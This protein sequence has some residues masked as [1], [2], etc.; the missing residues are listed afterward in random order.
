MK[1][2][3]LKINI[4]LNIIRSCLS[5][6]FPLITYPYIA[7]V[8]GVEILGK[9]N[10]AYSIENYFALI[11]LLGIS[12]YA[13]RTGSRCRDYKTE[14]KIFADQVYTVNLITTFVSYL[15]LLGFLISIPRLEPYRYLILLQSM[16]IL[17][18][19]IGADWINTIF[20]D[21][22]YV[23]LRTIFIYILNLILLFVFVNDSS[24]YYIYVGITVIIN[25]IIAL[26][27]RFYCRRYVNLC[28]TKCP[29]L[30]QHLSKMIIFF[31]NNLAITIYVTADITMLGWMQGDYFVGLYVIA[32]KVYTIVKSVLAATYTAVI[33]RLSNYAM[34]DKDEF[35]RLFDLLIC[36][37]TVIILPIAAILYILAKP[38]VLILAGSH[39]ID[40][41]YS[42]EI[43]CVSLVFSIFGGAIT[44]CYNIPLEKEKINLQA[45]IISAVLN[46]V[47]NIYFIAIYNH[48]GAA[49]TTLLSEFFIVL[50]CSYRD[51]KM[52]SR[53]LLSKDFLSSFVHSTISSL[54]IILIGKIIDSWSFNVWIFIL[55]ICIVAPA[56][57]V[58]SMVC[59]K[60]K[61]FVGMALGFLKK[62]KVIK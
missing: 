7:R 50:Y 37:L 53:Y 11:A 17:F 45:T 60:D 30:K 44:N 58:V 12:T 43:L 33:P 41:T 1:T 10:Y 61:F 15:F 31:A 9:V 39:F 62:V 26:T 35:N 47:L 56:T 3:S 36:N 13:V 57:Y 6:L 8:L 55:L 29:A 52:F 22:L 54:C 5:V 21:F 2:N 38:I 27:N 4:I 34:H 32:T 51:R 18:T 23:T 20:E 14:F 42:L 16:S 19:T 59:F 46:I 40:A 24:D 28:I 25:L 48:I 49:I